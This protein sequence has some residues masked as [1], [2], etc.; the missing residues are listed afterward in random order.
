M[1]RM[2]HAWVDK[3]KISKDKCKP[4]NQYKPRHDSI[5]VNTKL[6]KPDYIIFGH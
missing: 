3:L 1:M 2:E 4:V 6:V 5:Y